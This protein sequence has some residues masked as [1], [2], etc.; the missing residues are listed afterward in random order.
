MEVEPIIFTVTKNYVESD[1]TST[2]EAQIRF[3]K[4]LPLLFAY[5]A[6]VTMCLIIYPY[7]RFWLFK[8]CGALIVT[9]GTTSR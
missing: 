5:D 7:I 8:Q 6:S 3:S 1:Q 2:L 4:K 9:Q